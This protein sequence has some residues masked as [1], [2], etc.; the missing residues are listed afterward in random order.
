MRKL[1]TIRKIKE[2]KPIK[3]ADR[4]EIA[5]IDGWESVVKKGEFKIG[6]EVIYIEIDSFIPHTLA[7]FL[8]KGIT[9]M[10]YKGITG[11]P[12]KTIKLR[13][14]ISQGLILAN[15]F[16]DCK[17][18]DDVT[19]R[20]GIVKW[21]K[22]IPDELKGKIRGYMPSFVPRTKQER[23][24]NL[25]KEIQESF[26]NK[27]LFEVT[28]KIDGESMTVYNNNDDLSICSKQLS[29]KLTSNNIFVKV[30]N[31]INI[32]SC[33]K[34]LNKNIAIQGELFGEGIRGNKQKIKG[35]NFAIFNIWDI[36]KQRYYLPKERAKLYSSLLQLGYTGTHVKLV[37]VSCLPTSDISLLL[38]LAEGK[39]DAELEREGL[40][41]KSMVRNFSFK[42]ISNK[43]LLKS[44]I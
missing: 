41:Y 1:A 22:P 28:E 43:Y 44:N 18:Y 37:T 39:N 21:E 3:N 16:T 11:R 36:D 9:P 4:I 34:K 13:G 10:E 26:N 5:V 30:S 12:L 42:I 7:P 31:Q 17:L 38:K 35:N 23:C 24:Q 27:E 2:L 15:C 32:L 20:L 8:S 40:V 19:D 14:K 33:L 29:M 6:D 25:I